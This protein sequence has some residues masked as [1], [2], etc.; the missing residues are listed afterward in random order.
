LPGIRL[1]PK[2][3]DG[4]PGRNVDRKEATPSPKCL[5]DSSLKDENALQSILLES[6]PQ[7]TA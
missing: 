2:R 1:L 6:G 4:E 3:R 7:L 5:H